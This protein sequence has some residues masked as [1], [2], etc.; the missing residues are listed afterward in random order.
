MN[1]LEHAPVNYVAFVSYRGKPAVASLQMVPTALLSAFATD[2]TVVGVCG[3]AV[4]LVEG[5]EDE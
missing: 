4:R 3:G 2:V 1:A 5:G